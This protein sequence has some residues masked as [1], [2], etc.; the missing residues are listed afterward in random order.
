M[1]NTMDFSWSLV[2]WA[3]WEYLILQLIS[4]ATTDH[5]ITTT[6]KQEKLGLTQL[7]LGNSPLVVLGYVSRFGMFY[8]FMELC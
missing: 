6:L 4:S 7:R 8:V 1:V 2:Y 3:G 5:I